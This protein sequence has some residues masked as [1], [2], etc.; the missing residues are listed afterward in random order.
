MTEEVKVEEVKAAVNAETNDQLEAR[1]I[2]TRAQLKVTREELETVKAKSE[3]EKKELASKIESADKEKH[4]L[5]R[6]LIDSELKAHAVAAGITDIDF[7]KLIDSSNLKLDEKG[8]IEGLQKAVDDFKAAK[9]SLFKAEK[10]SSSTNNQ[11]FPEE[12]T[13]SSPV[14]AYKLSDADYQ[15]NKDL[16]LAGKHL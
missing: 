16:L 9:P 5:H 3:L 11:K 14:D 2:K 13:K 8:N 15:K 6:K 4:S 12:E 7:V 10:K 1:D